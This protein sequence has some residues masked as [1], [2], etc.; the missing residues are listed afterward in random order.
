MSFR[1]FR[2][3]WITG[4][5]VQSALWVSLWITLYKYTPSQ[6]SLL[7]TVQSWV[8]L[9]WDTGKI[10]NSERMGG[11]ETRTYTVWGDS[12]TIVWDRH[13]PVDTNNMFPLSTESVCVYLCVCMSSLTLIA[14]MLALYILVSLTR[15]SNENGGS[16][17]VESDRQEGRQ[18]VEQSVRPHCLNTQL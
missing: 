8:D 18:R 1:P 16:N 14:S 11:R 7:Y 2:H 13:S 17:I 5:A 12:V 9:Y 15:S 3:L 4:E 10:E 6:N